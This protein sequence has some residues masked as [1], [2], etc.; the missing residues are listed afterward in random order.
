MFCLVLVV[1]IERQFSAQ[2]SVQNDSQT[3][4]VHLFTG[5]FLTLEHLRGT[6]AHGTAP[7]LQVTRSAL[8][9]AGEAKV[10]QFD[11]AVL[12]EQ[13]VLEFKIAVNARL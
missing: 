9:L 11:I 4:D 10:D 5:V 2:Q 12:V 1:F 6:V 7:G 13:D 8:V 3:P